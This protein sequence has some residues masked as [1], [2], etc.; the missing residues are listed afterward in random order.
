MLNDISE[1]NRKER[2]KFLFFIILGLALRF[3]QHY[4]DSYRNDSFSVVLFPISF[5]FVGHQRFNELYRTRR[6]D[7]KRQ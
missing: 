6:K 2:E 7:K 5:E 3:C 4:S 1:D